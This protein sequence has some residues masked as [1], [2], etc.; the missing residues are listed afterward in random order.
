MH[1][2]G[3]LYY[4]NNKIAYQGDWIED[5][6]WGYGTLYNQD[7][8]QLGGGYSFVSFDEVDEYWIKY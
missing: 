3:T 7:P 1:G 6:L 2:K 4:A 8:Q 5:H